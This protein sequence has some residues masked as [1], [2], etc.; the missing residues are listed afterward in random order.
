MGRISRAGALISA[1]ALAA[2][3]GV[4]SP[5]FGAS[6]RFGNAPAVPATAHIAGA[7]PDT[8]PLHVTV[9]LQS[10]DPAGLA[11][12]ANAV[13][14]PGSPQY[15]DYISPAEFAQRFGATRAAVQAVETS[16]R[17]HGL[18]PG[19]V[20][21]NSLSIPVTA[22]AGQV[23]QAFSTSFSHVALASGASAIVNRQAP[24]LDSGI[25]PDVQSVLGLS[26][27]ATAKPL[28]IH[29]HTASALAPQDRAHVVTGGPQPCAAAASAGASQGG[30][31]ADQIAAA[32]GMSGLYQSGDEGA[33]QT[34]AIL[35]LEPYDLFDIQQYGACFGANPQIGN[36]SVDGG[37]GTGPGQGEAALD[38]ENVI[39]L[40]PQANIA[41]YEGPNSGNGPYDVMSTIINQ[42]IA[43]V[44]STSWGE[45]E[46][47]EGFGQANAENTLFQQA[48]TEGITV[49]SASGDSGSEDCFPA[50]PTLQVDDP[51]SQPY[52]T[53]V[54]GTSLSANTST[55]ARLSETVWNDGAT[56][57]ASGG[58]VSS[59]WPMPGYQSQAASFLHVINANSSG[60]TCAATSGDCREVPDVSADG[61]PATGY[62]IY[63][64][65]NNDAG[66][67]QPSGWQAVGGTSAAAPA[68]AALIALANA[69]ARCAGTPIGFANPALY[70][71]AGTAYG[72]DFDDITSGNNDMTGLNS[73]LYPAGSGYDMA[74]GLGSPNAAALAQSLCTDAIAITNPGP[75]GSTVSKAVTLQIKAADTRGAPI[76]YR[77]TGL[78]SGL[79]I[80]GSTGKITGR[81]KRIGK[82][83]VTVTVA[84]SAG[85]TMQTTFTWTIEGAPTVSHVSMSSIDAGRPKLAFTVTAGRDEPGLKTISITLPRGLHFSKSRATV[86]V[87]GAKGRH[88]KFTASLQ[89]VALVITVRTAASQLHIT[90]S[91]PRLAASDSLTAAIARHR[92]GRLGLTLR[93]TDAGKLTTRLAA[94]ARP[95]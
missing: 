90:I 72:S 44:V 83:D 47:L 56:V 37:A 82:S 79:S 9:T 16:L 80:D 20:S 30:Y 32:Y 29:P 55:G 95:S 38:I 71:A 63:W 6:V 3:L 64:N 57:G 11:A 42:H 28:L 13:S 39:G 36:T 41:V 91:S 19:P 33:G 86:T 66:P 5:A 84:D 61:D 62:M 53:G 17:A 52:V 81:P 26:T 58:G 74:T 59:F 45:C 24:A 7:V 22:T 25:A 69:S 60:A 31:T 89:H 50:P 1:C 15:R 23:A 93:V 76:T 4:A 94:R 87:T 92:A 18:D 68:W 21:A 48:A 85:T 78:P 14:T 12:L 77:A 51:A 2:T 65:G 67:G 49:V 10:Q 40:A 27:L 88:L 73:G 8:T 70:Y 75:Q 46:Q 34:V 54:G 35:E 43:Q